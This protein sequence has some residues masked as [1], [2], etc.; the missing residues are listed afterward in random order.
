MDENQE[1][2][3]IK[4]NR[5]RRGR[6]EGSIFKRADGRWCAMFRVGN[7]RASV[8]AKSK[9]EVQAKLLELQKHGLPTGTVSMH[10]YLDAWLKSIQGTVEPNT[11]MSYERH[12]R[13]YLNPH[14]GHLKLSAIEP[15]HIKALYV[16]QAEKGIS[17]AMIRKAATTLSVALGDA[18]EERLI[19]FNPVRGVRRPLAVKRDIKPMEMAQVKEFLSKAAAHR[20]FPFFVLALDSGARPGELFALT[21]ADVD[22]NA[23]SIQITKS[24]EDIAG[25]VRVKEPKTKQARRRIPLSQSTIDV[26]HQHRKAMLAE[27]N[28]KPEAPVFC[29][30]EG[31]WLKISDVAQTFKRV[32]K[33]AKL[34]G[35]RLYA[36]RH[37]SATLLLL[38]NENPKVVSERLGHSTIVLTLNTYAHCL[39]T[40]QKGA[41]EKMNGILGLSLPKAQN[42]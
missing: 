3:P 15:S 25:K 7:R 16:T 33:W 27:G 14:I 24:L 35:F 9:S 34:D 23:G 42:A 19:R 8:Y 36:L 28:L 17:P 18:V 22:F 31:G 11:Y 1:N 13:L 21:W 41:A 12:V 40:M 26:L 20:M 4:R 5:K 39:P 6:S 32:L 38:N 29:N 2:K 10:V 30:V 37:T